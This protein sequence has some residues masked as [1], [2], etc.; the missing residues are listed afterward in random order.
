AG[1]LAEHHPGVLVAPE[2][3]AEW[4]ADLSGRER[5]SGHLV[6]ERLEQVEVAP[7]HQRELDRR[8]GQVRG[9]LQAAEAA[10]DDDHPMRPRRHHGQ[11]MLP[12]PGLDG[13]RDTT[14]PA[15]E[16]ANPAAPT[17][18]PDRHPSP[19]WRRVL[20]LDGAQ[21]L[22]IFG[23]ATSSTVISRARTSLAIRSR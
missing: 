20:L 14:R 4:V 10:A 6:G 18:E 12:P 3:R 7:V 2:D 9:G 17:R 11:W 1:D 15:P 23:L 8:G 21:A 5:P 13:R 22:A 19:G 16:S